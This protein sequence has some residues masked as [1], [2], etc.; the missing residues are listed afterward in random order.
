MPGA[1]RDP[2]EGRVSLRLRPGSSADAYS[3]W[4]WANDDDSRRASGSRD[5]IPWDTHVAWLAARLQRQDC[6]LAILE[7]GRGQPLGTIRFETID[8]WATAR[9]SYAVAPE[10]RGRGYGNE[11]VARGVELL[12]QAHPAAR[13]EALVRTDNPRSRAIFTRLGWASVPVPPDQLRF[14]ALPV[15]APCPE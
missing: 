8:R 14:V 2:G 12:R 11:L 6:L 1:N 3:L 15:E 13:I 5:P 10:S 9:L 7:T 4:L